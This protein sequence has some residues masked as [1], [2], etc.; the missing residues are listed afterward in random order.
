MPKHR[1]VAVVVATFALAAV[2][3]NAVLSATAADP[4]LASGGPTPRG[5]PP[6]AAAIVADAADGTVL[7]ADHDRRSLAVASTTK[8]MTALV[9]LERLPLDDVV[10]APAYAAAG[11]ESTIGLQSGERMTVGDLLIGL[12]VASGNDAAHA[13]AVAAAGSEPAF[14]ALMNERAAQLG[15]RDTR[16]ADA[17]GLDPAS[18]SSAADLVAVTRALRRHRFFRATV[19]A[20]T[21]V[22]RSG[23]W[24]RTLHSTNDLLGGALG[25]DGVKTGHT[26]AAGYVLVGSA[27]RRGRAVVAVVLG[28]RS[29]RD[30]DEATARLLRY[31]L[32]R[33]R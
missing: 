9:A 23:A 8:L 30:R 10:A 26:R 32:R 15:M 17:S 27:T 13:L 14:V 7:Y 24:K 25:V 1:L 5:L 28:A 19:A 16:Y 18:R 29:E 33:L 4:R 22:L 3:L 2:A 31:G 6:H 11:D 20:R 21:V 12:L